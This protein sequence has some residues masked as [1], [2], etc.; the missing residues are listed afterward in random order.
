MNSLST[1]VVYLFFSSL[2]IPSYLLCSNPS[3]PSILH[4]QD[5]CITMMTTPIKR[6]NATAGTAATVPKAPRK[7]VSKE[8]LE[9]VPADKETLQSLKKL[10][11]TGTGAFLQTNT[12]FTAIFNRKNIFTDEDGKVTERL[13]FFIPDETLNANTKL[14]INKLKCSAEDNFPFAFDEYWGKCVIRGKL[15]KGYDPIL[16]ANG[17]FCVVSGKLNAFTPAKDNDAKKRSVFL[18]IT[19]LK[20]IDEGE[21]DDEEEGDIEEEDD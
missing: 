19:N 13:E 15:D 12:S 17:N 9:I 14:V 7:R 8:Q 20:V 10:K 4:L 5:D 11:T 18:V 21:E 16:P 1:L 3:C 2:F 6:S